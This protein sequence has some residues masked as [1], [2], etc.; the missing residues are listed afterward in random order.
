MVIVYPKINDIAFL[1]SQM[2]GHFNRDCDLQAPR[3]HQAK[4]VIQ[5]KTTLT[6]KTLMEAIEN[7]KEV[8]RL[9]NQIMCWIVGFET[10]LLLKTLYLNAWRSKSVQF[11]HVF[12]SKDRITEKEWLLDKQ[13]ELFLL[14]IRQCGDYSQ[15]GYTNDFR[16]YKNRDSLIGLRSDANETEVKSTLLDIYSNDYSNFEDILD[17]RKH[18]IPLFKKPQN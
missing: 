4:F 8:K 18:T 5:V 12:K 14:A 3:A 17:S 15:Y 2:F 9:N 10:K 11:L 6:S 16:I 7:L 1:D 13:M